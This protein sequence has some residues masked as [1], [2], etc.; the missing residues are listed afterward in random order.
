[1]ASLC[2]YS[3]SSI[4]NIRWMLNRRIARSFRGVYSGPMF[5]PE[6]AARSST[7]KWSSSDGGG[8]VHHSERRIART[9]LVADLFRFRFVLQAAHPEV[10]LEMS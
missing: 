10:M 9:S 7:V 3:W 4:W 5:R 2:R 1:M 8:R 6:L